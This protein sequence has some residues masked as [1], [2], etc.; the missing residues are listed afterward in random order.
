MAKR[1]RNNVEVEYWQTL[2]DGMVS[3][4]LMI[5]LILML[6]IMYLVRIPDEDFVDIFRGDS[7]EDYQDQEAGGGNHANGLQDDEPGDEWEEEDGE[8]GSGGEGG[9]NG[10]GGDDGEDEGEYDDPEPGAGEGT[11][12]DRAAVF[13]QVIDGETGR[14]IKLKGI[15]FEL[16]GENSALQ[17]LST[18]YPKRI[19]YQKYETDE[20]GVFYLPEKIPL[21]GYYLHELTGLPGYD[22]SE[23]AEFYID[24]PYDWNDPYVV[25]VEL[26]PAKNM[27]RLQLIDQGNG[28][29]VG[30]ASFDVIA[31]ENIITRDGT[32][33]FK[34]GEVVA[35]IELDE[36]GY[37]ESRELYLGKY[38]LRQ[39]TVPELYARITADKEVE[40][41][42]RT[43]AESAAVTQLAEEKTSMTVQLVD[44]LYDTVYISD[45]KFSLH[46]DDGQVIERM[47]TDDKGR[48]T[49]T[50]LRKNTTYHI[51]QDSTVGDY[52]MDHADHSFTVGSD[53]LINGSARGNLVLRNR[54]IRVSIGVRDKL[55][56]GQVSDVNVALRDS[57]GS[58]IK[59]WNTTGLEQT[60]TGL[61]PGEYKVVLAGDEA[62]EHIIQVQDLT[63]LQSF[64]FDRWTTVDIGA[65]FGLTVTVV[66]MAALLRFLL[67]HRKRKKAEE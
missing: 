10:E 49:V 57:D 43:S 4:L 13:V 14:T 1:N 38:K 19:D 25:T 46:S 62:N 53:G 30:G 9:E 5:L 35:S 63:E 8:D 55:F 48:F 51:R 59:N 31:A 44:A 20:N 2:A 16:Y 33:R 65:I 60:I 6:L 47:T 37:G 42:E 7:Y 40:I 39:N 3:L 29:A 32:T 64:Q 12:T 26:Y 24:R 67:K 41:E 21:A 18:Y 66:G 23:N 27:I 50:N 52:L 15:E 11:G 58:V 54:M 22:T 17:V 45:A 36:N 28:Q 34:E 61:T 56:R